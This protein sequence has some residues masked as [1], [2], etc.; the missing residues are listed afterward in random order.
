MSA[1]QRG[2]DSTRHGGDL[3]TFHRRVTVGAIHQRGPD[4]RDG[5]LGMFHRRPEVLDCG[6]VPSPRLATC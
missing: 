3:G 6:L 4:W 5:D 1:R 2:S